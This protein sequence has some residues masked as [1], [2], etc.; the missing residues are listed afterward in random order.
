MGW[1]RAQ[2]SGADSSFHVGS[3]AYFTAYVALAPGSDFGVLALLNVGGDAAAPGSSWLL[4]AL[5]RL[6]V[7]N[8]ELSANSEDEDTLE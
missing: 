8:P 5:A 3:G 6:D 4:A 1:S 2:I 7:E